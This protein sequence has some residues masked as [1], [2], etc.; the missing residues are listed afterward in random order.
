MENQKVGLAAILNHG[1][2]K[3]WLNDFVKELKRPTKIEV[4]IIKA[5][6]EG[7]SFCELDGDDQRIAID[8][9]MFRGAAICG[10]NLPQTEMFATYVADEISSFI[11]EFGYEELTLNELLLALKINA[12]GKIKNPA[13][14]DIEQVCFTGNTINVFYLGKILKNYKVLRDNLDRRIQNQIDGY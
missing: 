4:R 8:Q 13:G 7:L 6:S 1:G 14:E 9:I 5:R 11:L 10:C 3:L 12:F 2:R